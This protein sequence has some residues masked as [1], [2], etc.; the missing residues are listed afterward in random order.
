V[1]GYIIQRTH[2]YSLGLVFV[3]AH[4]II[5]ILAYFLI[6]QKIERLE[7]KPA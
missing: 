2:S 5:T 6:T 1:F 4:C 7:L 3:S